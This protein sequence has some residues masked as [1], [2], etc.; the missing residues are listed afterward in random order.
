[1]FLGSSLVRTYV[2]FVLFL[3]KKQKFEEMNRK[4]LLLLLGL[5]G[6][7][8]L[9]PRAV[10]LVAV[11]GLWSSWRS[12]GELLCRKASTETSYEKGVAAGLR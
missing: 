12:R 8:L 11:G 4:L 3:K 2:P 9:F 6:Q 1:M 10:A 5:R 7:A